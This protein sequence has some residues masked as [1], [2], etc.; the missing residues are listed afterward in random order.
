M[1]KKHDDFGNR[2]KGYE[3]TGTWLT[4]PVT[5]PLCIRIDGKGF[6]KFTKGFSKPFD[7]RIRAAMVETTKTL[8]EVTSAKIGYTQSDEISLVILPGEHA[9]EHIFGGKVSKLNS[10]LASVA[11]AHFNKALGHTKLAYFDCRSFGV[12]TL[13]EAANVLLWRAQDAR[14][15]SISAACRW[16]AG[17][18]EMQN[19]DQQQMI[20]LMSSKYGIFWHGLEPEFKYGTLVF[21]KN[22]TRRAGDL[23]LDFIPEAKRPDPD[24]MITRRSLV[25]EPASEP[26]FETYLNLLT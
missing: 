17:H 13:E 19:L 7:A 4:V 24:T 26:C 5:Q 23:E 15:N 18:R 10:I 14:K 21:S 20:N 6:S 3:K 8:I 2:M 25:E 16:I 11:T 22:M 1:S 9:S 12:P